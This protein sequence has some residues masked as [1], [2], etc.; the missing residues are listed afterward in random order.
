LVL[1][2]GAVALLYGPFLGNPLVFDDLSFFQGGGIENAATGKVPFGLRWLPQ[3]TLGLTYAFVGASPP[4]HRF[5]NLLL[6][7]AVGAALYALFRM[8]LALCRLPSRK[9]SLGGEGLA[10]FAAL[11]FVL[12]PVAVYGAGYLMQRTIVMATLFSLLMWISLLR[13]LDGKGR[14]WIWLSAG[15]YFL[16]VFSKELAIMA[17]AVALALTILHFRCRSSLA[18]V[19]WRDEVARLWPIFLL[20]ALIGIFVVFTMRGL[21]GTIYEPHVPDMQEGLDGAIQSLD[22]AYLLSVIT[23][24]WQ[25]FKYL[26]LWLIPN[27][28][29]MSIDMREPF[30]TSLSAWPLILGVAGYGTFVLIG[31]ALLWRGGAPGLAGLAML[32]PALLYITEFSTVRIQEQFV[33]YRSYL[34]MPLL[35]GLLPLLLQNLPRRLALS[36]LVIV[37]FALAA[38][39]LDRLVTFSNPILVWDDAVKLTAG[40]EQLPGTARTIYIRGYYLNKYALPQEAITD[41]DRALALRPNYPAALKE[42]GRAR[43]SMGQVKEALVDF[44]QAIK[45]QPNYGQAYMG[46]AETLMVLGLASTAQLDFSMAC[47]LGW[48]LACKRLASE[49][50]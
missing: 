7:I 4:W 16:S 10:L 40:R 6:H 31:A 21:L 28:A 8:L 42:R 23:Q 25:F 2:A 48:D 17:P 39:S 38:L 14:L 11:A 37:P 30:A 35:F 34:W 33:L 3:A 45:L 32:A 47:N 50:P 41:F 18:E 5:G 43:L 22:H 49:R 44:N 12:N 1:L 9:G 19:R 46:R 29:W 27:P 26:I 20:Y 15:F 36:L 13:G 24:C